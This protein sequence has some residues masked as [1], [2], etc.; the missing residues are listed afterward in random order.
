METF[1]GL[2]E[3]VVARI[4]LAVRAAGL[5]LASETFGPGV[6]PEQFGPAPDCSAHVM[7]SWC[8]AEE[9]LDEAQDKS[10][11]HHSWR[12]IATAFQAMENALAQILSVC[13]LD[14]TADPLT[15]SVTVWGIT[16]PS[17]DSEK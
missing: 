12:L 11:D 7:V 13:G 14:V 6:R 1:P 9:L 4:C 16:N 5:P 8:V 10:I 2:W 3:E 17:P 15:R